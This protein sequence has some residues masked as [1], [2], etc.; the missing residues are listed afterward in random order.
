ML[1]CFIMGITCS[2]IGYFGVRHLWAH[3]VH[4]KWAERKAKRQSAQV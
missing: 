2:S 4:K 1:G 3:H